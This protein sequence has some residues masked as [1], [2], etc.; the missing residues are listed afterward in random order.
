MVF[1]SLSR[2]GTSKRAS[3]SSRPRATR[4]TFHPA[5]EVPLP[6]SKASISLAGVAGDQDQVGVEQERRKPARTRKE[7]HVG[8]RLD[9]HAAPPSSEWCFGRR[10]AMFRRRPDSQ[11]RCTSQLAAI[12]ARSRGA[13]GI[14]CSAC[15]ST[16]ATAAF[17]NAQWSN[18]VITRSTRAP[19]R[20][21]L[22]TQGEAAGG[23]CRTADGLRPFRNP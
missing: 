10:G 23:R 6:T 7:M 3:S 1:S 12:R 22:P 17:S 11:M 8:E 15:A 21:G 5:L 18:V 2:I 4:R 16:S 20:A 13:I 9:D 19:M 14:R